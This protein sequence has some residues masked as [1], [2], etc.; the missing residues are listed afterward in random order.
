MTMTTLLCKGNNAIIVI[1]ALSCRC[2]C[3]VGHEDEGKDGDAVV[4]SGAQGGG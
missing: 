3:V 1:V 4:L 2:H